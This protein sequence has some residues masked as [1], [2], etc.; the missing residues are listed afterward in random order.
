MFVTIL[1]GQDL[2]EPKLNIRGF[3]G[4]ESLPS[5]L[6][7]K[8]PSGLL[9]RPTGSKTRS[10]T[11]GPPI[12]SNHFGHLNLCCVASCHIKKLSITAKATMP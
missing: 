10:H 3:G 12:G 4:A 1:C 11:L 9:G 5:E 2:Q 7:Q 8:K 6:M